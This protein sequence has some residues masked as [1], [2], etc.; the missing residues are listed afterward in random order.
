ML[1]GV[2]YRWNENLGNDDVILPMVVVEYQS[3][4][5]GVSYDIDIS[6]FNGPTSGNGGPELSMRYLFKKVGKPDFCPTC[7]TYL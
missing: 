7:P 4:R 3:W 5:V 6:G 2:N 1:F